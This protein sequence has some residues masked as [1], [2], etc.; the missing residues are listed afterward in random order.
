MEVFLKSL[1]ALNNETHVLLLHF[2][3][4][5]GECCVCDGSKLRYE[6]RELMEMLS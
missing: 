5:Y 1:P 3:D 6:S 4:E 2:L